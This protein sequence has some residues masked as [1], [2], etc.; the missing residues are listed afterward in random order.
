MS[1]WTFIIVYHG[2]HKI[3]L[4]DGALYIT[5]SKLNLYILCISLPISNEI[6]IVN[7]YNHTCSIY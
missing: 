4:E 6:H 2:L 7:T 1:G 5:Y 3:D